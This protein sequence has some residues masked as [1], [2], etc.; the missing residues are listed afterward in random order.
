MYSIMRYWQTLLTEQK[1][2]GKKGFTIPYII[3]SQK[4]L[5]VCYPRQDVENLVID[6][7]TNSLF[8]VFLKYCMDAGDLILEIM[9]A[10]A[11]GINPDYNSQQ[12]TNFYISKFNNDFG[13]S[14]EAVAKNL[15]KKYQ[16]YVSSHEYS[17]NGG[18]RG[19]FTSKE[20]ED[21]KNWFSIYMQ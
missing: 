19:D 13:N 15:C 16:P 2:K 7:V 12:Q 3:G 4:Y 8:P 20:K 9:S 14:I 10:T 1:K 21:I 17:I 5:P 11:I 18:K 6:M